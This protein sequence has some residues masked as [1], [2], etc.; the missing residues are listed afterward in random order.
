MT[1]ALEMKYDGT[2]F[3]VD[4]SIN[5]LQADKVY[6]VVD[7]KNRSIYIWQGRN[8]GV[9]HKFVGATVARE[10]RLEQGPHFRVKAVQQG[11]EPQSFLRLL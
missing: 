4:L 8:A 3:Q 9:R 1:V 10:L 7:E 11:E 2:S 6:C 5:D